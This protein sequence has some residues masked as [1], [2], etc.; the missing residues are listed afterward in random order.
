MICPICL[1]KAIRIVKGKCSNCYGKQYQ[2]N[3]R[4]KKKISNDIISSE[5]NEILEGLML[6]DGCIQY[7]SKESRN[8]RLVIIR[9]VLD[10]DYMIWQYHKLQTLFASGIKY[11]SRFDKRTEKIYHSVQ[12]QSKAI[13]KLKIIRNRWYPNNKKSIP[14]DLKLTPLI[15][16]VWFCDDGSI[17]HRSKK[18]TELKLSTHGF[19]IEENLFLINLLNNELKEKFRICKDESNFYISGS[20]KAALAFIKYIDNI[21]P[22]CMSRKS[23]K[24]RLIKLWDGVQRGPYNK[25]NSHRIPSEGFSGRGWKYITSEIFSAGS[26]QISP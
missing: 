18:A 14:L 3:K 9:S 2:K 13:P 12:L 17:I 21:F 16:L 15:C 1:T 20:T 19:S 10:E 22:E 5:Q 6:G 25:I 26:S 7:S 8:P 24:W 4:L 23:D 11:N